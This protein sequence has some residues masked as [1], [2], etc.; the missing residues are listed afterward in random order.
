MK[1]SKSCQMIMRLPYALCTRRYNQVTH[2]YFAHDLS[3]WVNGFCLAP[4]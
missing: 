1:K 4:S 2:A 3:E